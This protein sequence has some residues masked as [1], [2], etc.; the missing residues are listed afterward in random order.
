MK[1]FD[2]HSDTPYRCFTENLKP[3]SEILSA[4]VNQTESFEK[5]EQFYAV[6]IKDDETEPFKMYDKIYSSFLKKIKCCE[7]KPKVHFALEGGAA[8]ESNDL[9]YKLKSDNIEY[10]TLTWNGKNKIASGCKADGGLTDFG[11]ETVKI[12]NELKIACDLSHSNDESFYDAV[13]L[14]DY[15][16]ITHA[17]LKEICP[18][19]RNFTLEQIRLLFE[20]GG[21]LGICFYPEFTGGK[22]VF[23]NIYRNVYNILDMGFKNSLAIGSDFDGADMSEDLKTT[24]DT[25]KLYEYLLNKGI[26]KNTLDGIFYHNAHNYFN[27][28]K[29]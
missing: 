22:N 19:R 12:M 14:S 24:K 21:I 20:K 4:G 29:T 5:W 17:C 8:I 28:L 23:E 1:L 2:L 26:D 25:P 10:I 18:N 15:P 9:L 13:N 27:N 7:K 16:I 6:W 3:D 11:R